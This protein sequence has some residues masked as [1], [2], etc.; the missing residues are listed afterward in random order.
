VTEPEAV[1]RLLGALE[2]AALSLA[3]TAS[4]SVLDD[5][6][7]ERSEVTFSESKVVGLVE[8]GA[9][10]PAQGKEVGLREERRTA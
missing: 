6:S 4:D 7:L 5:S 9:C 1:R 10:H 3:T 8:P 2:L